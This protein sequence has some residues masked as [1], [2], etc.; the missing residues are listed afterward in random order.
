MRTR[1]DC[2]ERCIKHIAGETPSFAVLL[3][4]K[5]KPGRETDRKKKGEDSHNV[6]YQGE[7]KPQL[8]GIKAA[9][10]LNHLYLLDHILLRL[11]SH[12]KKR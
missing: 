10:I 4:K 11:L 3:E 1:S 7:A 6:T 12:G 9:G 2:V 8:D 5:K